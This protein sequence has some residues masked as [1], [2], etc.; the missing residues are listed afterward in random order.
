MRSC[1]GGGGVVVVVV[2]GMGGFVLGAFSVF[3]RREIDVV[4]EVRERETRFSYVFDWGNSYD[5]GYEI[6]SCI[7]SK[8]ERPNPP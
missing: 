1:G 3:E 6:K 7:I 5:T 8:G 2:V 4:G